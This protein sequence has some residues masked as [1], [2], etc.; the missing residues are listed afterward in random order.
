MHKY[1]S[2]EQVLLGETSENPESPLYLFSPPHCEPCGSCW[3][4]QLVMSVL[5]FCHF[6]PQHSDSSR[7]WSFSSSNVLAS[8]LP[9]PL[10]AAPYVP[11]PCPPHYAALLFHIQH[12][13]HSDLL[14]PDGLLTLCFWI[15]HSTYHFGTRCLSGIF[16]LSTSCLFCLLHWLVSAMRMLTPGLW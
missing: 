9:R 1:G 5:F 11:P 16:A 6:S 7:N 15:L 8:F 12:K 3:L 13:C 10:R 14:S 4:E 2:L